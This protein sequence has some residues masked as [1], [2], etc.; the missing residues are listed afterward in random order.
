MLENYSPLLTDELLKKVNNRKNVVFVPF[1]KY[2]GKITFQVF[3]GE[4]FLLRTQ[5][6]DFYA[7]QR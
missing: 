4:E 2:Q 3:H 5:L 1:P 7:I 6:R